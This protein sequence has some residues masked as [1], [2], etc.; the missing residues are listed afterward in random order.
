MYERNK[1]W[2]RRY[3]FY[4]FMFFLRRLMFTAA[5]IMLMDYLGLC[6]IVINI[7]TLIML[8]YICQVNPFTKRLDLFI[9]IT[10]EFLTL[11]IQ[12]GFLALALEH[13]ERQTIDNIGWAIVIIT[14][15]IFIINWLVL[16]GFILVQL[17]YICKQ[18]LCVKKAVK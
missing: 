15:L 16:L 9:E 18:K 7:S 2:K 5:L 8:V 1:T 11:L 4:I 17:M 3:V 10:N 13:K 14:A 6:I 12:L